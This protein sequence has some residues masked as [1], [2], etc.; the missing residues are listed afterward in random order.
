MRQAACSRRPPRNIR[1]TRRARAGRSKTRR[2]GGR[3]AGRLSAGSPT[4]S[5]HPSPPSASPPRCLAGAEAP[6]R[7]LPVVF[8]GPEGTGRGLAAA[9]GD[10]GLRPGIPVAAGGGD[11]AAAAVGNGVIKGGLASCSIGTSGVLFAHSDKLSLDP[12]GRLHAFCH[13]VPGRYHLMG[14]TLSAGGSLRWW[15]DVLGN[16]TYEEMGQLAP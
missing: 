12:S 16:I 9:A 11:N 15:R 1:F 3:R 4:R 8:E 13:A 10:L 6:A 14:V 5:A 7:W 2:T